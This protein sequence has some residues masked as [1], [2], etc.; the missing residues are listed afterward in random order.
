MPTLDDHE[1]RISALEASIPFIRE[2]IEG[3][4][5]RLKEL[6]ANAPGWKIIIYAALAGAG[7][8][9]GGGSIEELKALLP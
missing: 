9:V 3:I 6:C 1:K 7:I 2:H 5:E 4:E 8:A